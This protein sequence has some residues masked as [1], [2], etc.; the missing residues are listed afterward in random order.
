[1]LRLPLLLSLLALL[2]ASGCAHSPPAAPSD[3]FEPVNRRIF[4]FNQ[5]LD[6]WVARPVAQAYVDVTPDP[7]ERGISNFL[8]NLKYPITIANDLF[9][10]K[11]HHALVGT[12]RFLINSTIGFVGIFDVASNLGLPARDED[13]GQTL[14]YW[15]LGRG[16]YLVLPVLGPS[17]GRDAVGDVVDWFLDPTNQISDTAAQYALQ[18][19]YLVDLRASF[20]GFDRA[21]RMAFDPYLFVRTA[22]LQNRRGKV[23]DGNPPRADYLGPPGGTQKTPQAPEK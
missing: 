13:F 11:F 3:P 1:M 8:D 22:Y 18:A 4:V 14:G 6:R 12:G 5:T 10:A 16:P 21:L 15:G 7:V 9:Q 19:L 23:Y 17:S 2:A 20:L